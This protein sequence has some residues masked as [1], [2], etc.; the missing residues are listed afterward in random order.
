MKTNPSSYRKCPFCKRKFIDTK[1]LILH[2]SKY[3]PTSFLSID[4]IIES[5]GKFVTECL[6]CGKELPNPI[7]YSVLE[8]FEEI[9][10]GLYP[11]IFFYSKNCQE[12]YGY[13]ESRKKTSSY[14]TAP[15][16]ADYTD[17]YDWNR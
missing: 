11:E 2:I 12:K 13:L 7:P 17:Q 9:G 15:W 10:E 16:S 4:S 1:H 6:N 14:D 5:D 3:H 8:Y